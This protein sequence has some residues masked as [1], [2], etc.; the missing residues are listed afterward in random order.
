MTD[1]PTVYQG[2]ETLHDG[3]TADP[4][5]IYEDLA[6]PFG[7]LRLLPKGGHG[8]HNGMRSIIDGLKGNCDFPRLRIG[9][10]RPPEKMDTANYVLSQFSKEEHEQLDNTF[11]TGLK[12]IRMLLFEGVSDSSLQK[13]NLWSSSK[14]EGLFVSSHRKNCRPF[15]SL[16][17]YVFNS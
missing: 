17:C 14:G 8:G 10:G 12:G 5:K 6:L 2:S 7:T 1:R 15:D 9:I 16:I 11:R 13:T 4:A 3:L